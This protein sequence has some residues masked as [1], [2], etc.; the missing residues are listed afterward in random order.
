MVE[1]VELVL[2]KLARYPVDGGSAALRDAV[3]LL[4]SS[5]IR[6]RRDSDVTYT[7]RPEHRWEV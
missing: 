1:L 3:G 7:K 5:D 2:D 6:V 4:V